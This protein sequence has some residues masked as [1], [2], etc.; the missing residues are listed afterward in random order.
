MLVSFLKMP[1]ARHLMTTNVNPLPR[2]ASARAWNSIRVGFF[3]A[4]RQIRANVGTT[5]LIIVVMTLTY[6]NLLVMSGVMVG[7]VQGL[8]DERQTHYSGDIILTNYNQKDSIQ[9]SS[10]TLAYLR[11]LPLVDSFSARYVASGVLEGNYA[12]KLRLYDKPDVYGVNIAGI[13]PAAENATTDFSTL[14]IEGKYLEK[15][16]YD[17]VLIGTSLLARYKTLTA[18][19]GATPIPNVSVGSKVRIVVGGIEREMTVKGI[20][21]SKVQEINLRVF[22][23]DSQLRAMLGRDNGVNE[24]AVKLAP[25]ANAA[26]VQRQ[27][28]QSSVGANAKIELARESEP[29][30]FEDFSMTFNKLGSFLGGIGLVIAF[31][32]IFILVFIN[33]IT[34]RRSIGILQAI[35]IQSAGIEV[36][37]VL[38][39]VLYATAGVALGMLILFMFL[40]PYFSVHP[41]DFP[42]SNGIL[43]VS[44]SA[45]LVKAFVLFV[46]IILASLI[47]ARMIMR[48]EIVDA[49]LGR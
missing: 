29:T 12:G 19:P 28:Q 35:G 46:A 33:T 7:I 15:N 9:N 17:Q 42:F 41:I 10:D 38:Q 20:I 48:Q 24:I 5:L 47:P 23:V 49:V 31:I 30:F 16:D 27:I 37:Y 6:L 3:L 43:A 22:I 4:S 21:A 2:F 8:H 36:G 1:S 34:R 14:L 32:A 45:A 26:S 13:D 39:S 25:G 18:I 44:F 40:V 11:A